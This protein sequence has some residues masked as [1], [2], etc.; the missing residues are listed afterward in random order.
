MGITREYELHVHTRSL[1]AWARYEY[2]AE[3]TWAGRLGETVR[4][5]PDGL[6][7]CMVPAPGTDI[8][9]SH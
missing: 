5:S 6:W 8:V 9:S 2:G 7:A 3:R 4:A 1:W